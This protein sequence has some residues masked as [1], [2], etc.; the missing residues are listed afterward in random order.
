MALDCLLD[1]RVVGVNLDDGSFLLGCQSQ[2]LIK[3]QHGKDAQ[4]KRMAEGKAKLTLISAPA[5]LVPPEQFE[6]APTSWGFRSR[7]CVRCF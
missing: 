2:R 7:H 3:E 4:E 6:S 5:K 1:I